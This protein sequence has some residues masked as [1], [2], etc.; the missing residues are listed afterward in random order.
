MPEATNQPVVT[1]VLET[2]L[3]VA[4]LDRSRQFYESLFG[5]PQLAGDA[6]F[7]ALD[8]AGRQVL[9]LFRHG[10]SLAPA[11]TS[12]GVLP[13]HDGSGQMHLAFAIAAEQWDGWLARLESAGVAIESIINWPRGVRSVYFRD[14][15]GHLVELVTPG[16]WKTY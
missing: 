14:P 4:D 3:Y 11:N 12:G 8:V 2:S 9:L 5:F 15:D 10:A 1:G 7:C 6:R 16:C 13:P